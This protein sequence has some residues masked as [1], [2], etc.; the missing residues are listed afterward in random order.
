MIRSVLIIGYRV[1]LVS[2]LRRA[3]RCLLK[4]HMPRVPGMFQI[5]LIIPEGSQHSN[6]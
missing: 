6:G 5:M 1:L 3:L 2:A 4:W